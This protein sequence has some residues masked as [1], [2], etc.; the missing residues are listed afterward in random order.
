MTHAPVAPP[1]STWRWTHARPPAL[2]KHLLPVELDDL[3]VLVHVDVPGV[4]GPVGILHGVVLPV[5]EAKL[6]LKQHVWQRGQE[7]G[8]DDLS[9][10][11]DDARELVQ[12]SR[13]VA[14][15]QKLSNS[16]VVEQVILRM[17]I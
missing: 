1:V 5:P 9:Q 12:D 13:T 10:Q 6:A 8:R 15:E 2:R 11:R 7:G 14:L 16:H 17:Q 3:G 4:D